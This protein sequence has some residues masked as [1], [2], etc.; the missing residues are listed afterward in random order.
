MQFQISESRNE[1]EFA[2]KTYRL[3]KSIKYD[4]KRGSVTF[5][6]PLL[7]DLVVQGDVKVEFF[8]EGTIKKVRDNLCYLENNKKCD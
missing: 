6:Q 4:I 5:Q 7:T 1:D 8:K 3:H 2:L